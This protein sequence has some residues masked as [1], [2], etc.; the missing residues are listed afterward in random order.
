MF[1]HVHIESQLKRTSKPGTLQH[2]CDG[3][4]PLM[5][6]DED[7]GFHK[8]LGFHT[9]TIRQREYRCQYSGPKMLQKEHLVY[10][11]RCDILMA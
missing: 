5:Q 11:K 3:L 2:G 1:F 4:Q 10:L 6:L 8:F 7:Q 9:D